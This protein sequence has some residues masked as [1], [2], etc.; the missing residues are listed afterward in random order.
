[1]AADTP[2]RFQ[3]PYHWSLAQRLAHYTDRTGGEDACWT[4]TGTVDT[5]GYGQLTWKNQPHR[6]HR[7]AWIATHGPV[8]V[9]LSV[10]HRCDH[11]LCCNPAHL[12]TGTHQDNMADMVAKGRA[13]RHGAPPGE[14]NWQAKLT[15]ADVRA[16]R[17]AEG[18]QRAIAKRFGVS[19]ETVRQV[20]RGKI[21]SH[22]K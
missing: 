11:P 3:C 7:L 14:R 12:R 19:R 13:S 2:K 20:L 17:A 22:V 21:W 4:W 15:E 8:P 16:I 18:T 1:M 5:W 9:G 6:A 10:C